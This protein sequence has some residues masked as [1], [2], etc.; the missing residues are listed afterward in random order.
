MFNAL[1]YLLTRG[2]VMATASYD[3]GG[4]IRTRTELDRPDAQIMMAPYSLDFSTQTSRSSL[5]RACR[6]LAT[7]CVPRAAD[8]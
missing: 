4:F 6:Y 1:R 2:G 7:C 5:S 8:A 3:V